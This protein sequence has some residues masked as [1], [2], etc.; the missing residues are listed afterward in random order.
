MNKCNKSTTFGISSFLVIGLEISTAAEPPAS[1]QY[2]RQDFKLQM[3]VLIYLDY[4]I[5]QKISVK[6]N[7]LQNIS[8]TIFTKKSFRFNLDY[9]PICTKNQP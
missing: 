6:A 9:F 1:L 2:L 3:R 5:N 4:G 7:S 8:Y